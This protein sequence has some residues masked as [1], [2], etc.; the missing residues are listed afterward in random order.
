M[1]SV[2]DQIKAK[3]DIV[4]F[5]GRYVTLKKAG[6]HYTGLCPFH[7]EKSPSFVVTPERDMWYCFGA[8]HEGGDAIAFFMKW[9]NLTFYEALKE[10]GE[11][12][13]I[14][15]KSNAVADGE[16]SKKDLLYRVNRM[17]MQYYQHLLVN[18]AYGT[19]ALEYLRGRGAND[20]IIK[21]FELGYAPA[22]WDS[23]TKF[24]RSKQ[25]P[26]EDI[27]AAGLAVK[28]SR[29]SLYDRLRGRIVFPIK[30][31]RDHVV[32]FSGRLLEEDPQQPKYLNIAETAVYHKRESLYG[33]NITKEGIRTKKS[34][35][36]V[37]GEFDVILPYEHG[38]D[39]VVA[40]KGSSLTVEHL[41]VLQRYAQKVIICLDSDAA[42]NDAVIR[43]IHAAEPFDLELQVVQLPP[44]TDPADAVQHQLGDF[45]ARL[46]KPLPAYAYVLDAVCQKYP[47]PSP[48]DQKKIV[49]ELASFIQGTQNIIVREYYLKK[50][51]ERIE[52][53]VEVI[54]LEIDEM[55]R[56]NR[57]SQL[58]Q[59][60]EKTRGEEPHMKDQKYLLSFLFQHEN[61]AVAMAQIR[62]L[63]MPDDFSMPA[64]G[65][66]FHHLQETID[67]GD[68][69]Q[70]KTFAQSLPK[71][72]HPMY[73]EVVYTLLDPIVFTEHPAKLAKTIKL[74]LLKR[75]R[76]Q[77]L[78][79][80][81]E[82]EREQALSRFSQEMVRI[83]KIRI[84]STG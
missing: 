32:G 18:T 29:G 83:Q 33:I 14:E 55:V 25:F 11:Q 21:T 80:T 63:I 20:R 48:F 56:K 46:K 39:N 84:D 52:M 54:K 6:R 2:V 15:V 3:L 66:L 7:S 5:I 24:L 47:D 23:L 22:S 75:Y 81:D 9:E 16:W 71:E 60:A 45:K 30:D 8:C 53:P 42:G 38:I 77:S 17:A 34:A 78:R 58:K 59:S 67:R 73:D 68:T 43:A 65:K 51:S 10:L 72:L 74:K 27:L 62:D 36:I 79:I 37:E 28:S 69:Y 13:G 12:V 31:I 35:L 76:E 57:K 82:T 61:P 70:E 44:G 64:L 19:K 50:L 49:H 26:D 4:E 40:I 1:D 41:K